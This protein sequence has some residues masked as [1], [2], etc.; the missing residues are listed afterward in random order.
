VSIG[1]EAMIVA[2][3]IESWPENTRV[4]PEAER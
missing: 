1:W 4:I 2:G 3:K